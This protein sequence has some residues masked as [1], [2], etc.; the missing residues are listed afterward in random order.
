[1]SSAKKTIF[2]E[3]T[4]LDEVIE[5]LVNP[6]SYGIKTVDLFNYLNLSIGTSVS[7][8][9]LHPDSIS[10]IATSATTNSISQRTISSS[11]ASVVSLRSDGDNPGDISIKMIDFHHFADLGYQLST[12]SLSVMSVIRM[13]SSNVYINNFNDG[14]NLGSLLESMNSGSDAATT[15]MTTNSTGGDAGIYYLPDLRLVI[16]NVLILLI[17]YLK[18]QESS[19]VGTP[20]EPMLF[21]LIFLLN[22][23]I[24]HKLLKI[25][26]ILNSKMKFKSEVILLGLMK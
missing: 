4:I 18:K 16:K 7:N 25:F 14:G 6:P 23:S 26:R 11:G 13:L 3:I 15:T 22:V 9:S 24:V 5:V 10:K 2:D 1:M 12:P 17:N 8:S 21:N 19:A 20:E